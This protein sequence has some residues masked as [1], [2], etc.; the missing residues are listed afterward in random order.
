VEEWSQRWSLPNGIVL[1]ELSEEAREDAAIVV[2]GRLIRDAEDI[3]SL[4]DP[5]TWREVAARRIIAYHPY[6]APDCG[7]GEYRPSTHY[8]PTGV[9]AINE[10]YPP[11]EQCRAWVHELAHDEL[12]HWIPPQL[13]EEL[14]RYAYDGDPSDVR[15]DIA[16]RAER[17]VL[18]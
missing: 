13:P 17:L 12:H 9:I 15:H 4:T 18:G 7:R 8:L 10:A 3:G 1:P 6:F 11:E 2:A 16:R 5:A 14:D